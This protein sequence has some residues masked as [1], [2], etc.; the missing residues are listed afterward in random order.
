M[1]VG[2]IGAG[3]MGA[4]VHAS[5]GNKQTNN[6][7]VNA[8][9]S[10]SIPAGAATRLDGNITINGKVYDNLWWQL[11]IIITF[12]TLAGAIIPEV[13]KVFTST[14]SRHVKEVVTASREGGASLN[15][16]AGFTAGNFSAFWL[17][18]V[19]I[20]LMAGASLVAQGELSAIIN[21]DPEKAAIM[22]AVFSFG[23][24]AF[25]F[26]GMGPVTIAVDSY[27]PVT[28][29]AQS[30]YE[31]STIEE[32]PGV[33]AEIER[34]FGFEPQWESL[35]ELHAED[36]PVPQ[37]A[38]VTLQILGGRKEKIRPGDVLGALTG[39]AGLAADQIGKINVNEQSTYVAV[40][41]GI[42]RQ[43]LKRLQDGK[44]KGK[45]VRVRLLDE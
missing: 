43:A 39:E 25:G 14:N 41:R 2:I 5:L 21:P 37:P 44:I 16:L 15:I 10:L 34:D 22:A 26:L 6:G 30:V 11:S 13:V 35:A 18:V 20:A 33:G 1:K 4:D 29:N 8:T 32:I 17:G 38:M 3:T 23:L 24:V 36:Q 9:T 19:I 27:G 12:G 7:A 42:A 31:L 45:K 28:D 40:A